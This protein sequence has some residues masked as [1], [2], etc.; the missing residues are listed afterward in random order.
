MFG[1]MLSPIAFFGHSKKRFVYKSAPGGIRTR[2]AGLGSQ[3][4]AS[5]PL[6]RNELHNIFIHNIFIKKNKFKNL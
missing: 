6:A 3:R 2:V 4:H 1:L 5:R